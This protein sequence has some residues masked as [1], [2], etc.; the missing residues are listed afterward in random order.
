MIESFNIRS[1][2]NNNTLIEETNIFLLAFLGLINASSNYVLNK[3]NADNDDFSENIYDQRKWLEVLID[4]LL[5]IN[6]NKNST[7]S[8]YLTTFKYNQQFSVD[9]LKFLF[10]IY[11]NKSI[12]NYFLVS[13]LPIARN[14]KIS[15][16][17]DNYIC[18]KLIEI[19]DN[20]NNSSITINSFEIISINIFIK[21]IIK[22]SK[23]EKK[24][25]IINTNAILFIQNLY[26]FYQSN[27]N[28]IIMKTIIECL[29]VLYENEKNYYDDQGL[30]ESCLNDFNLKLRNKVYPFDEYSKETNEH[31][32]AV[33][34]ILNLTCL[35][36]KANLI[37]KEFIISI[38]EYLKS[39][40]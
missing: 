30:L 38:Y 17:L 19:I 6:E 12:I 21:N 5:N 1:L 13:I 16:Y 9:M 18:N 33:K 35:S 11:S 25:S 2:F 4:F 15:E 26:K 34:C 27:D 24:H 8:D 22:F 20:L 37:N 29:Y 31:I 40:R 36:Y 23:N 39:V 7:E 32:L 14:I 3:T 10:Q 28:I